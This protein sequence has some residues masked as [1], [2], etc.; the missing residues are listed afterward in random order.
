MPNIKLELITLR[1][2]V[3]CSTNWAIQA[4][5]LHVYT[6]IMKQQKEKLRNQSCLQLYQK[7][8]RYL[9]INLTKEVKDLY[10]KNYKTLM[11]ETEHD[12]KKWKDVRCSW[13]GRILW[14]CLHYPKQS[15][16]LQ[17]LHNAIPI[18]TPTSFFTKQTI[19]K[20]V[21]NHRRPQ[22]AKATLKKKKLEASQFLTSSYITKL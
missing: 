5:L 21:W 13:I 20:F 15:T 10:S 18:K 2:Q 4:P 16:H 22:I 11:K 19:L 14:K 1:L 8:L 7:T 17:S 6:P 3:M 12:T 9:G